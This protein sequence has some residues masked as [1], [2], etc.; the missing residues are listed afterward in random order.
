MPRPIQTETLP[1][2]NPGSETE[3]GMIACPVP[4]GYGVFPMP[5]AARPRIYFPPGKPGS[6]VNGGDARAKS[7]N[8]AFSCQFVAMAARESN[9]ATLVRHSE[10]LAMA[11]APSFFA[12]PS[13]ACR[14]SIA[15]IRTSPAALGA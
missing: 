4:F 3:V 12:K 6:L 2:G 1:H 8:V 15:R 10:I 7:L 9:S 13:Y 5:R 14:S 11:L